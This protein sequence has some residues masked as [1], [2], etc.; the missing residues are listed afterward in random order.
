MG[1]GRMYDVP[2]TDVVPELADIQG[3]VICKD[4][5]GAVD[6][7]RAELDKHDVR[8][9]YVCGIDTDVCVLTNAAGLFDQRFDVRV[10]AQACGSTG[11]RESHQAGLT[12]LRRIIGTRRVINDWRT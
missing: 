2:D 1:W 11:G 4:A 6:D 8:T 9:V 12:A 3:T 5:Y 10:V 7:I